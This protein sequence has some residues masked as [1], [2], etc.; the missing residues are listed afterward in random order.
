MAEAI[1]SR[2]GGGVK[3]NDTTEKVVVFG[4]AIKK[5]DS[6]ALVDSYSGPLTRVGDFSLLAAPATKI[7]CSPVAPYMGLY[8]NTG[9]V[10]ALYAKH[11]YRGLTRQFGVTTSDSPR[12]ADV[13]FSSRGT[14]FVLLQGDFYSN[15]I[16]LYHNQEGRIAEDSFARYAKSLAFS[17]DEK[18]LVVTH[19]SSGGVYATLFRL[20]GASCTKV[21]GALDSFP[22][23]RILA[24]SPDGSHLLTAADNTL[25]IFKRNGDTYTQLTSPS[26]TLSG[27]TDIV[28]SPDG[29]HA[30]IT[31]SSSPYIVILKRTA[32]TYVK[33][34][35]PSVLPTGEITRGRAV[36][37]ANGDYL[38]LLHSQSPYVTLYKR[39]GDAFAKLANL[40]SLNYSYG[41][42]A[43]SPDT[44]LLAV[45]INTSPYILVYRRQGDTFTKL[46]NPSYLPTSGAQGVGFGVDGMLYVGTSS[47]PYCVA[48][49]CAHAGVVALKASTVGYGPNLGMGYALEAGAE[50]TQN[51]VAIM[52]G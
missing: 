10:G 6:I 29:V 39:D 11:G 48:Y 4:E 5:G 36:F 45:G 1:L 41:Y 20:E 43:F 49:Q 37:S 22:N 16:Y 33:L 26:I 9:G 25:Y 27:A 51:K 31:Q 52:A 12:G 42:I 17:P 13:A 2:R 28:F 18:H 19:D 14:Y 21:S 46:S 8:H 50:G 15:K 40:S 34:A 7:V 32:D 23:S 3:I 24:F 47:S 44:S 38:A 30:I 35:N